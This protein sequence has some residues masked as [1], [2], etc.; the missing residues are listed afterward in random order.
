MN[1]KLFRNFCDNLNNEVSQLR[2]ERGEGKQK[3]FVE[4]IWDQLPYS[5]ENFV[6]PVYLNGKFGT[7][8]IGIDGYS[9]T[10]EKTLYLIIADWDEF[11]NR[12]PLTRIDAEKEGEENFVGDSEIIALGG[13]SNETKDRPLG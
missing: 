7:R 5:E 10:D 12:P 4:T 3:S 6:T 9:L 13:A 8:N 1:E 2:E 11:S